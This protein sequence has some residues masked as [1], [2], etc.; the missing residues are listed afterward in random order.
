MDE[1]SNRIQIN[2]MTKKEMPNI[3]DAEIKELINLYNLKNFHE[4]EIKASIIIKKN[5]ENYI[6]YNLSGLAKISQEKDEE[7]IDFY[8]KAILIKED[9]TAAHNNKGNALLKKR[10]YLEAILSFKKAIKYEVSSKNIEQIKLNL[11][12]C[13]L[14]NSQYEEAIETYE[15]IIKKND[16]FIMAYQNLAFAESKIQQYEKSNETYKKILNIESENQEAIYGIGNNL[17]KDKMYEK[18]NNF[19]EN[20]INKKIINEKI[21][22]N[23]G[24]SYQL[25]KKYEEAIEE[26]EKAIKLNK[27]YREAYINSS[28]CYKALSNDDK[29]MDNLKK[30]LEIDPNYKVALKNL[31]HLLL[32]N[33][34]YD[35][36]IYYYKKYYELDKSNLEILLSLGITYY[37]KKEFDNSKRYFKETL[38]LD[39][40]SYEAMKILGEIAYL[41]GDFEIAIK[42]LEKSLSIEDIDGFEST[43]YYLGLS[44]EEIN[45]YEKALFCFE[46]SLLNDNEIYWKEHYLRILYKMGNIENFNEKLE[47]LIDEGRQSSILQSIITHSKIHLNIKNDYN[48]CN[49]AIELTHKISIK[50]SLKKLKILKKDYSN[51]FFNKKNNKIELL[52]EDINKKIYSYKNSYKN[53]NIN[54]YNNLTDT[55]TLNLTQKSE[56]KNIFQTNKIT[57]D[58][59]SGLILITDSKEE[60]EL[61]LSIS[62]DDY[63]ENKKNYLKKKI[64]IK[65]GDLILYPSSLFFKLEIINEIDVIIID[66]KVNNN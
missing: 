34:E 46:E 31:A 39:D 25:Q 1:F 53:K 37:M 44:Y 26:F 23:N 33:S 11:G 27:S 43:Y 21:Y 4:L 42:E 29:S 59:L 15:T 45:N 20:Y 6:A 49:N 60:F 13:Y 18:A 64:K 3:E 8:N 19:Y 10:K 32:S 51:S 62:G 61:E 52:K 7:A 36:A 57:N 16:K 17:I 24:Y 12:N 50:D 9:Y 63:P 54:Y 41:E 58:Y 65:D 56:N 22:F 28:F 35:E 40:Q 2:K 30:A 47:E 14:N 48:F 55:I 5:Q 38:K 66:I